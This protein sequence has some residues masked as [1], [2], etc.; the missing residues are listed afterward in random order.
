LLTDLIYVRELE[1]KNKRDNFGVN[2]VVNI[3]VFLK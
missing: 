1:I 3:A 2:I